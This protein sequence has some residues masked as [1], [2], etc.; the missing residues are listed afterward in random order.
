MLSEI[1]IFH[2]NPTVTTLVVLFILRKRSTHFQGPYYWSRVFI[3]LLVC[4]AFLFF[5]THTEVIAIPR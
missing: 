3:G 5:L 1:L 2:I 4:N